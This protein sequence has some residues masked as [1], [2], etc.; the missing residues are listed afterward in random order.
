M[1]KFWE[2]WEDEDERRSLGA[3]RDKEI[4]EEDG[5]EKGKNK[6]KLI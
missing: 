4:E 6:I 5:G 3:G 1:W 2:V